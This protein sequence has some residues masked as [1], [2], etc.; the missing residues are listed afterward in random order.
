MIQL[1][2]YRF[3]QNPRKMYAACALRKTGWKSIQ[4][5]RPGA[6]LIAVFVCLLGDIAFVSFY[7]SWIVHTITTG[8]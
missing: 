1:D 5:K 6:V 4:Q 7:F 2:I 3:M 8:I